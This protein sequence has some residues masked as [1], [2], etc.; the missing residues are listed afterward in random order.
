M[1]D[2]FR[3]ELELS[4]MSLRS[5]AIREFN[6]FVG[7]ELAGDETKCKDMRLA[8]TGFAEFHVVHCRGAENARW[9]YS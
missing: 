8:V 6:S 3:V 2:D 7:K 9:Q 5:I 4:S 1:G